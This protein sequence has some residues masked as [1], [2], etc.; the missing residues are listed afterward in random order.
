QKRAGIRANCPFGGLKKTKESRTRG[1]LSFW[2]SQKDKRKP[3]PGQIVLLKV[4][5]RQKRAGIRTNCPFEGLK[6]TKES[7]NPGKLSFWRFQKDK[8][9]P[10]P[11]QIVLLGGSKR[12]K[13]AGIRA[14]CS[15]GGLKTTKEERTRNELSFPGA[16]KEK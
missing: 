12:Q 1:K 14:N 3:D 6:K 13:R 16:R 4:S 2:R 11:G 8:R 15:F 9:K 7:W 10:D 5:K